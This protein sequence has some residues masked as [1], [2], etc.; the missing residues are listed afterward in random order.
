MFDQRSSHRVGLTTRKARYLNIG[1][2]RQ[3]RTVR[4]H[5]RDVSKVL[6]VPTKRFNA[7]GIHCSDPGNEVLDA[8]DRIGRYVGYFGHPT[9]ELVDVLSDK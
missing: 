4:M 1:Q 9:G 3:M 7:W 8:A 2:V 6:V 5:G